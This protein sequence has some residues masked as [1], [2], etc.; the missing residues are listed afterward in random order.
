V[1]AD[2]LKLDGAALQQL[3]AEK[4]HAVIPFSFYPRVSFACGAS[5]WGA[6]L[7]IFFFLTGSAALQ[8]R[9]E[10]ALGASDGI[11]QQACWAT[12]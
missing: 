3:L 5:V 6:M 10:H 12:G 1:L 11:F 7:C 8:K 2:W 9:T 4:V